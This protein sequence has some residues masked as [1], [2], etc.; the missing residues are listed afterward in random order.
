MC[1]LPV[2]K[3]SRPQSTCLMLRRVQNEISKHGR[4]PSCLHHITKADFDKKVGQ[5][6]LRV[7]PRIL[8]AIEHSHEE[9][10]HFAHSMEGRAPIRDVQLSVVLQDTECLSKGA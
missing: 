7:V 6:T 10:S 9:E 3:S 4:I 2:R 5:K 1:T 8:K